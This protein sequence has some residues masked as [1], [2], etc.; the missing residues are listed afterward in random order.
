MKSDEKNVLKLIKKIHSVTEQLE[1]LEQRKEYCVHCQ[2]VLDNDFTTTDLVLNRK[3]QKLID[4][5]FDL[6]EKILHVKKDLVNLK[7]RLRRL[8]KKAS[9]CN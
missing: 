8:Y 6:A 7:A 1:N 9:L 4:L 3:Y 5:D 2:N